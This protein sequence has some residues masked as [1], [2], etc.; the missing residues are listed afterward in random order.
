MSLARYLAVIAVTSCVA[1]WSL[2][3]TFADETVAPGF[4][5]RALVIGPA[6][7]LGAAYWASRFAMRVPNDAGT[8]F[9]SYRVS[10]HIVGGA[11]AAVLFIAA[12]FALWL[13]P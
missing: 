9:W 2:G 4:L 7:G 10:N 6:V 13:N 1:F 8:S 12:A 3:F 5:W 11:W